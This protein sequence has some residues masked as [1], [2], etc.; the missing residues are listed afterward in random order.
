MHRS[1]RDFPRPCEQNTHLLQEN[2]KKAQQREQNLETDLRK[3]RD[4]LK[5]AQVL[6]CNG[7]I[8]AVCVVVFRC[9]VAQ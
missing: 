7:V 3:C 6:Y 1:M 4:E 2:L 9:L 5:A 8:T